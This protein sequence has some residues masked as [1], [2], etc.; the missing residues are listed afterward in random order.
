[1]PQNGA[2]PVT[3]RIRLGRETLDSFERRTFA[4]W[5]PASLTARRSDRQTPGG[6]A[7]NTIRFQEE[8]WTL[9]SCTR[10]PVYRAF[11]SREIATPPEPGHGYEYIFIC[12]KNG[13]RRRA[14]A[15][16][17]VTDLAEGELLVI[18]TRAV[19]LL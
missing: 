7:M 8:E 4:A 10:L 13:A 16:K 2:R 11:D 9:E 15:A 17:S 6:T 18:A 19:D 3:T 12:L 14:T 1:M 5:D